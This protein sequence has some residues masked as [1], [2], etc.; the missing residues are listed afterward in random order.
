M[1]S[2]EA[3]ATEWQDEPENFTKDDLDTARLLYL[4]A[5]NAKEL[6]H[7]A[8]INSLLEATSDVEFNARN[9]AFASA[10]QA[11]DLIYVKLCNI[12]KTLLLR[13]KQQI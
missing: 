2:N 10:V 11:L 9:N 7:F 3:H 5:L 13:N 4:E 1:D 8:V 12:Q 6:A